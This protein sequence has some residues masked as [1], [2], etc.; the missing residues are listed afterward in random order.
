MSHRFTVGV[1]EEFQ[2]VDPETWELRSHVS[3]LLASG[4]PTLGE[5]I[6]REMHQSIVEVGTKICGDISELREEIFR[7]RR[8]LT[9]AADRV[10][11]AVAAAGTHP[12]SDWKDQVLPPGVR[13]ENI[14]EELQQLAR[15]LLIFGLHVHVA[16]PD[17]T[18]MIDL[19]NMARYF[20]PHLLAL[21]TSSPFWMGREAGLKSYRTTVF[22]RFP[23]TGVPDHFDSWSAYENYVQLLVELHC[24]EDAKKIWWDVRP[25]PTFGTL[26][27]RVC[28][29]TT[30][31]EAAVMIAALCQAIVVKLH[32]LY[33]RNQGFR[34]YRRALIEE[35]KWR[36]ARWGIDG[37]LIDF[38]KRTEVPMRD[39]A[40]ELLEFVDDVVDEL[41][42]RGPRAGGAGRGHERG[43]AAGGLPRDQRP[44]G[45]GAAHRPGDPGR[46]L[47]AKPM[48][49]GLLCGRE[50]S[51]PPAFIERV[52]ERGAAHGI[53]AAMVKFGGTKMDEPSQYRVIVDRISHEVEYYRG[54]LKHAVLHGAYVI[55][56]PFW[57]T[58]DDKFFNYCVMHKLGVAIPRTVLL[59]QKGYP[60]DVDLT[61]E[62]LRNLVYPIDWDGLLDYVGRP[63]I[64]KPYSG[65]GWRH[66]YKVN[67]RDELLAAYEQ[68]SPYPMTL[69]QFIDF[70]R[71]V[72]C[73]TFGKTDITP[74]AYD[75]RERRYLVDH[76]YLS[77]ELGAR[78]V[79]DA[80]TINTALGY[81]M[82]TIEFAIQDD[83]PYAID[84]LNPAPDFE[85][86]RITEFYFSH[87]IEKMTALVIDR[88]LNGQP[89]QSWPRWEEMLGVGPAGGY[90]GAPGLR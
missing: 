34:L 18:T 82:N 60:P 59:P 12:F 14:V 33:T 79:R 9:G 87:V 73:F 19:M 49:I 75:P 64:L 55:N 35:N 10:G 8:E 43:S 42:G 5:H 67:D 68:T 65:G 84:Y 70:D 11:L 24:I 56:N 78:V 21:S 72:R 45:S 85:R 52:N 53:T 88:A 83:V 26:E 81:E 80:Q 28:D 29:V 31:A 6:K 3:E 47:G 46:D 66:V 41:G 58:A 86:D 39:L 57:W 61:P 71:Y 50:Y 48:K 36:A 13:Y 69:Q 4:A 30:R 37:K 22:R 1:E 44:E 54:A 2:I 23:R 27:F 16:V 15:S 7:M 51:F 74:V 77:A 17:R 63:A 25:H 40:M 20:L 38:G 32:K 76:E 89:S 90:T 62:S